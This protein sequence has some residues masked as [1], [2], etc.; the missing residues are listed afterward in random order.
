[1][2][3]FY[4]RS[5]KFH[6]NE[7]ILPPNAKKPDIINALYGAVYQEFIGASKNIRY[8]NKSPLEKMQALNEFAEAWLKE[9][10]LL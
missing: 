1:M 3:I 7:T 6:I 2:N 9:R 4:R 10:K 8:S 5:N